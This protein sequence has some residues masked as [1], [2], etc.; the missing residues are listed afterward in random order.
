MNE[1]GVI[2]SEDLTLKC[3]KAAYLVCCSWNS[4]TLCLVSSIHTSFKLQ[5]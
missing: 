4:Q 5:A 1:S 3:M 2:V